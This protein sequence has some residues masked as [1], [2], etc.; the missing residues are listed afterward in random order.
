MSGLRTEISPESLADM[1]IPLENPFTSPVAGSGAASAPPREDR[2][3]PRRQTPEREPQE[4]PEPPREPAGQPPAQPRTPEPPKPEA[5]DED[6]ELEKYT[7][8]ELG[9]YNA[10]LEELNE[11]RAQRGMAPVK[12]EAQQQAQAQQQAPAP[13]APA[14][15][16]Q[17]PGEAY[18]IPTQEEWVQMSED[19]DFATRVMVAQQQHMAAHM[20]AAFE[21][22][23]DRK[24]MAKV[25]GM[26]PTVHAV[27]AFIDE[28]PHYENYQAIV[29]DE[30]AKVLKAHPEVRN[31][32]RRAVAK[33]KERFAEEI[34]RADKITSRRR[35]VDTRTGKPGHIPGKRN[36]APVQG[37]PRR[38]LDGDEIDPETARI[39][40]DWRQSSSPRDDKFLNEVI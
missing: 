17:L 23:L 10:M 35:I 4:R 30:L 31:S 21:Q 12:Q 39:F 6:E 37:E 14:T 24:L 11:L 1:D 8:I 25:A 38:T 33:L 5:P 9:E 32:P 7:A 22:T 34:A 16:F 36:G 2:E 19:Y 20:M 40:E 28:Y 18:L 27:Q 29:E 3:P 15:N 13:A 26:Y